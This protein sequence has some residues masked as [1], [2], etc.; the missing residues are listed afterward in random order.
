MGL[1]SRAMLPMR[2]L[3]GPACTAEACEV[4][5]CCPSLPCVAEEARRVHLRLATAAG[6]VP[7]LH[8][9]G[10]HLGVVARP[11]AERGAFAFRRSYLSYSVANR[12]IP[13][14]VYTEDPDRV[15]R[16]VG[17]LGGFSRLSAAP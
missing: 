15:G 11:V 9:L 2:L 17:G 7:E 1:Q 3:S 16:S 6:A 14:E 13:T 10:G 8:L 5:Q 12:Q 4:T